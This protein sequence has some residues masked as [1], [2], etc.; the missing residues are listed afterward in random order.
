MTCPLS[1]SQ[2]VGS[3]SSNRVF[4]GSKSQ[5]LYDVTLRRSPV[6]KFLALGF[7]QKSVHLSHP[8]LYLSNTFLSIC[9]ISLPTSLAQVAASPNVVAFTLS[10]RHRASEYPSSRMPVKTK[11]QGP[12]WTYLGGMSQGRTC[13]Q[14]LCFLVCIS[15]RL[16]LTYLG[17]SP[18]AGL[19]WP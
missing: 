8:W 4:F 3:Q 7:L 15:W 11:P 10:V 19:F 9:P 1:R 2:Q 17:N 14:L 16:C 18:E 6:W 13:G 12:E 5:C